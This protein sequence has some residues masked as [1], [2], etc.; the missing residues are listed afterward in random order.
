MLSTS[1]AFALIFEAKFG[2]DPEDVAKW[3]EK[4]SN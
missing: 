3:C 1:L 2:D 4:N